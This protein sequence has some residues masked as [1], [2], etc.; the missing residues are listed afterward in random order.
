MLYTVHLDP[1]MSNRRLSRLSGSSDNYMFIGAD[2]SFG[3]ATF[4]FTDS[5]Q[6]ANFAAQYAGVV[7]VNGERAR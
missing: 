3:C 1:M 2:V 7:I 5:T 4:T 6:A